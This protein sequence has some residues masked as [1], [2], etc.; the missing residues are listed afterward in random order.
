[1]VALNIN[2]AQGKACSDIIK[3][4]SKGPSLNTVGRGKT[5]KRLLSF[6]K[7]SLFRMAARV[8]GVERETE[9]WV[10]QT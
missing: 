8:D 5:E 6:H 9:E 4:K 2:T 7:L 3:G 1:M 10:S